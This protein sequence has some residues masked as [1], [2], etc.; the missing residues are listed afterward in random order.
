MSDY[1]EATVSGS[2]WQRCYEI[3]ISN[4]YQQAPRV[5][6]NEQQ[7][8]L[9]A[10]K[11]HIL[12]YTSI[13]Q[14]FDP[15]G[16]IDIYDPDTLQATGQQVPQSDLYGLLFSAYLTAAKARDDAAAAAAQPVEPQP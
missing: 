16:L 11:L 3:L 2:S 10:D 4:H 13:E 14:A 15:E 7:V 6:F 12:G 5:R 8:A 9:L 1:K